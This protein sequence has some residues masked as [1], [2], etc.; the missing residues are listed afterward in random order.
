MRAQRETFRTTPRLYGKEGLTEMTVEV[1]TV[2]LPKKAE[3][4]DSE[5]VMRHCP[6]CSQ[7]LDEL[8]CQLFCRTCG[9]YMS[10]ADY[11]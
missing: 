6:N 10:C 11:Y 1:P 7:R 9:Y 3:P 5:E 2:T 8:K 4:F